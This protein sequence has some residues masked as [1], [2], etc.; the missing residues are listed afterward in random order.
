MPHLRRVLRFAAAVF[1]LPLLSA[2][3][4]TPEVKAADELRAQALAG[5]AAAQLALAD[6]YLF[7]KNRPGNPVLAAYWYRK[8]AEQGNAAA[9]YNLGCCY[10]HGWGVDKCRHQALELYQRAAEQ[11]LAAAA[12]RLAHLLFDGIPAE[13]LGLRHFSELPPDREA[14]FRELRRLCAANYAPAKL[15]LAVLLCD[16]PALRKDNAEEIGR[17]AREAAEAPDATVAAKL[18]YARCLR[19]GIGLIPNPMLAL[20]LYKEAAERG[21]PSGMAAYGRMLEFGM[22]TKPDPA[23]ALELYEKAAKLGDPSGMV[24]LGDRLLAEGDMEAAYAWYSKAAKLDHGPACA[25]AGDCLASG[26]GVPADPEAAVALYEQG[27]K[28]GDANSQYKLGKCLAEGRGAKPDP[29]GA[30]FWYKCAGA[31][32][33]RDAVRELGT[34]LFYGRGVPADV[35]EGRRLLEAAAKGG[36]PEA[37]AILNGEVR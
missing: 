34:A 33:N 24:F 8:A 31:N 25:K 9:R 7:G 20:K 6:E 17:L 3:E 27:A 16:D 29:A 37:A 10:E 28:L 11:G 22:G 30:V 4:K 19:H 18:F 15:E 13:D 26:W 36:D 1:V 32:G 5:D 23:G 14:A 35:A 21:D 2:A 12:V